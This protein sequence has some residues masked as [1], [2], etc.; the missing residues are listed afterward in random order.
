MGSVFSAPPISLGL[1]PEAGYAPTPPGASLHK[2]SGPL[3]SSTETV[4]VLKGSMGFLRDVVGLWTNRWNGQIPH[5]LRGVAS[6]FLLCVFLADRVQ[7]P[8]GTPIQKEV[9]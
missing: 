9:I 2:A 3:I 1:T 5:V 7:I 4:S 6:L 8:S